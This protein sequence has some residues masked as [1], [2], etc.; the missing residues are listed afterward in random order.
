MRKLLLLF[1]FL[2]F[3]SSSMAE[4]KNLY[5][6]ILEL[7]WIYK[8]FEVTKS[9]TGVEFDSNEKIRISDDVV[10]SEIHINLEGPF[11]L[12]EGT[13]LEQAMNRNVA[14][15][16]NT[17]ELNKEYQPKHQIAEGIGGIKLE[18]NGFEVGYLDYQVPAMNMAK[19][20]RA[21]LV[22][23]NR[24]YG[25]TIVFYDPSIDPRRGMIFD[26]FVIAAVNSGKL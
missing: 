11:P 15:I 6:Y 9:D 22:K 1:C 12:T 2:C 19:I 3:S 25:F 17:T 14:S 5:D 24:L 18:L 26:S 20:R 10:L 8:G 13:T 16:L 21:I 23:D 4:E 7:D